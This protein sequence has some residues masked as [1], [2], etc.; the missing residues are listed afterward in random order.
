MEAPG[1][2]PGKEITKN[3]EGV[4]FLVKK[5]GYNFHEY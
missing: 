2:E 5:G 4:V 1:F 3:P